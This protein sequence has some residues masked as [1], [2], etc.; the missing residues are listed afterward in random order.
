MAVIP[1]RLSVAINK[2][3][4]NLEKIH[5]EAILIDMH[6]DTILRVL[7]EGSD[8]AE[9]A[10]GWHLDLNL[11]KEGGVD[12]Q[13][14]SIWPDPHEFWGVEAQKRAADL[15]GAL[16]RQLEKHPESIERAFT[17][18]DI[19]RIEQTGKISALM[20]I[21]G[22][23]AINDD[24]GVLREFYDRGVRY[25]TLTHSRTTNWAGSSGDAIGR[26]TGLSDFGREVVLEM[27]RLGML[28]DISHVSDKTFWDVIET[29]EKPV[30][31][32]HSGA[33]T[34]S[35]HHRNLTD[36]MITAVA[37]S[38]GVVCIVFYPIFLSE[39][40]AKS[41]REIFSSLKPR[42]EE[43][44]ATLPGLEASYAKDRLS[45]QTLKEKIAPMPLAI[46]ADHIEHVVKIAGIDHVGLGSDFDGINCVPEGL[47]TGAKLFALTAE[48]AS[49][50]FGEQE[51]KKIL[52][53]NILRI[54]EAQ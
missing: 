7:D 9:G 10:D 37:E 50:G 18:S 39:K 1:Y 20:G 29:A 24:L 8:L 32:S 17:T 48:L 3:P 51:L 16:D 28:V 5:H 54:M 31:A 46:L 21:E 23:H 38:G 45:A 53:G 42:Y 52:G 2:F 34:L 11:M 14:F 6:A 49:R 25:M 12:A 40:Y 47:E 27:N 19:Y 15:I 26:E 13:F 44:D 30:I 36:E 41:A 35:N 4:M 33:R 22:G 43:I